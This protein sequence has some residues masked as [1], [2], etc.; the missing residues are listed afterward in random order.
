[1]LRVRCCMRPSARVEWP[2]TSSGTAGGRREERRTEE[3]GG[4]GRA[5]KKERHGASH[6]VNSHARCGAASLVKGLSRFISKSSISLT[7]KDLEWVQEKR[8]MK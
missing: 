6:D 8:R 7:I 4:E 1:M 2:A 5:T 3:Q